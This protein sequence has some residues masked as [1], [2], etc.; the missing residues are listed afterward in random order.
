M[1]LS[2]SEQAVMKKIGMVMLVAAFTLGE[3]SGWAAGVGAQ[4]PG[5][6][7]RHAPPGPRL[8]RLVEELGLDERTLAQVDAVIDASRA[9]ERTLRRQLREAGKQMRGL[10]E[11]EEPRETDLLE[12]VEVIGSLRT[13]LRKEQLK[14]MLRVRALL[15]LEQRAK[16]LE[17]FKK[18]PRRGHRGFGWHKDL[19]ST[20]PP[21]ESQ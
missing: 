10:L 20:P 1:L 11:E 3:W 18:S 2:Y 9:K 4:P 5:P 6:H 7:A 17:Q 12:Q 13:A 19:Q 21:V 15:S 16:L 14:T 8:E